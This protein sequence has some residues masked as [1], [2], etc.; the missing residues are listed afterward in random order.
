FSFAGNQFTIIKGGL[1]LSLSIKDWLFQSNLNT[2][3]VQM[4]SDIQIDTN[5]DN[6]CN[7]DNNDAEIESSSNNNYLSNNI[8]YLK[9][10]KNNRILYARFQDIMLSDNRPTTIL[11]KLISS[12]KSSV[13][14][15][16]NLPHCSD[17]LIDP[18]FSLLVSTDYKFE[19]KEKSKKWIIAVSV[20]LGVVAF[21]AIA[22]GLYVALKK[23]TVL[24]IKV[25]KLKKLLKNNN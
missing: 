20:I 5:R 6:K 2:L 19:C 9:I 1:K 16:L 4:S 25:Y 10:T 21:V 22:I 8:N 18:D 7:N 3:Q 13:R 11:A 24:K 23:S 12:D 17:C 14:I 15:G